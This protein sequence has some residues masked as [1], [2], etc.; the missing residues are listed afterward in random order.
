[1]VFIVCGLDGDWNPRRIDRYR[2][3]AAEALP[4]LELLVEREGET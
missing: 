2:V 1:V 4:L 3:L